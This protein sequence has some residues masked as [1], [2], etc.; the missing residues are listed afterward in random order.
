MTCSP[1][2]SFAQP[3]ETVRANQ[4]LLALGTANVGASLL[5]GF[6]VS[7]S[8]SRTAIGVATGSRSQLYSLAAAG[9]VLVAVLFLR[10]VL[11]RF[12]RRR[13]ARSSSTRRSG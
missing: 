11:A 5:H 10:P 9:A 7:S 3:A 4:E 12:P 6:P 2:R 13:S 8:A 1:A